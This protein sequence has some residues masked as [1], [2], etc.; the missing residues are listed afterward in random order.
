MKFAL[1]ATVAAI[2]F[3]ISASTPR[4]DDSAINAA[5]NATLTQDYY[6]HNPNSEYTWAL[7][8][9]STKSMDS[10]IRRAIPT[11]QRATTHRFPTFPRLAQRSAMISRILLTTTAA[12]MLGNCAI[13]T[14]ENL[15]MTA[16]S[17]V[18][19]CNSAT[20]LTLAPTSTSAPTLA[21]PTTAA[22]TTVAVSTPAAPTT[23]P[24][25]T[26]ATPTPTPT[27]SSASTF[28]NVVAVG[29]A[30]SF[31]SLVV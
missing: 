1:V 22:A 6:V 10:T 21:P 14:G 2:N 7:C 8:T 27:Q 31:I 25:T 11:W 17:L 9:A 5:N 19:N 12:N 26:M 20:A 3:A 15:Y 4:S 13:T 24:G 28:A 18:N 30:A 23:T 16:T 29:L